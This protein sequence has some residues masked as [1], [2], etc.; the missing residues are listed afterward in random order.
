MT[1]DETQ[2]RQQLTSY[3]IND[4]I[5]VQRILIRMKQKNFNFKLKKNNNLIFN[6][7]E[8]SPVSSDDDDEDKIIIGQQQQKLI[9]Q[10]QQQELFIQQQ[11]QELIIQQPIINNFE[12]IAEQEPEELNIQQQQ[13]II[14][15]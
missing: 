4:C 7:D 3:A 6:L 15:D 9:I 5:A 8:L 11:P 1:Y 14:D 12:R 10:Q 2:Y 13:Q